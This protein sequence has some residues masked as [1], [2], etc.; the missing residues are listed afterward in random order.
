MNA[1]VLEP[2]VV[3][4]LRWTG[5]IL[6]TLLFLFWGVFFVEH[7]IEWFVKPFPATPP[8]VVW[9]GQVEHLLLLLGLLA[10]WRWEV[11]GGV[12]VI[13]ASLV[14]FADK[15]GANF[16]LFFGVTALPAALLLFCAWRR[17][18]GSR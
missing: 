15:A 17:H 2:K 7:L 9:L 4:A 1:A 3:S 10:L 11:A 8:A 13:A 6:A 12:L 18:A 14:F 5:R 16:P